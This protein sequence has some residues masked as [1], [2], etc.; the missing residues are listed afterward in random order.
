MRRWSKEAGER[1]ANI[2]IMGRI[3]GWTRIV[4]GAGNVL[5][6]LIATMAVAVR[7]GAWGVGPGFALPAPLD[8]SGPPAG[9]IAPLSA[10][11]VAGVLGE[12]SPADAISALS[13]SSGGSTAR[14]R[15]ELDVVDHPATNDDVESA[16]QVKR[17]PFEAR[18]STRQAT[19]QSQEPDACSPAGGSVWYRYQPAQTQGL[20]A[21]TAGSDYAIALGVFSGSLDRLSNINCDT[22]ARG[23]ASS[24]FPAV[25]GVTYYFQI[26]GPIQ[27]GQLVFTLSP[28]ATTSLVSGGPDSTSG[29]GYSD[30]PALSADGRYVAFYGRSPNLDP[31]CPCEAQVYVRDLAT[32]KTVLASESTDGRIGNHVSVEPD[33]SA[34]GRYVVFHS[35]ATNLV[36]GDTNGLSDVFVRDMVARQ[37]TRV[38]VTSNGGQANGFWSHISA[39]GRYVVFASDAEELSGPRLRYRKDIYHHDR[40]TGRT[41]VVSVASDG[42]AANADSTFADLSPEGR[43]VIFWSRA[44]NLVPGVTGPY[45][46]AMNQV[47]SYHGHMFVNDLVT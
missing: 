8:Y 39:T 3:A 9:E 22:D 35:L 31:R 23:A 40:V 20:V 2:P 7:V 15:R 13:G 25:A 26:T 5:A 43:Y 30:R 47:D 46:D 12:Y 27:G 44:S 14:P 42:T 24:T 1:T 37:T 28:V 18:T 36:P 38:S 29:P 17:L 11:Y 19:R 10:P 6:L 16:Y 21:S 41:R 33:I 32:G 4:L 34:D 45:D